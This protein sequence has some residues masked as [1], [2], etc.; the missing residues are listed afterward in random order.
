MADYSDFNGK[1]IEEFRANG[2][3]VGGPFQGA[4]VLLLHHTGARS[5]TERVSPLGYQSV[6]EG[7][8]VFAT[9]AGAPTNPDW[10]HNLV[11]NPDATIEVG[12]DTVKVVARVA[13][14]T[15][16]DVIWARQRERVAQFAQYEEQ[17][18]PR[19][20]PVVVLDPVK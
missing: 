12:T 13:E 20:I 7:Y 1:V 10:Y 19:K 5:G 15:E 3:K 18:A 11:A 4:D 16:R 8:A 17:A 9:K 14:P 6:G 2:G